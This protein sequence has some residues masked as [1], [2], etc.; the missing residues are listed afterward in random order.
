MAKRKYARKFSRCNIK[1]VDDLNG[2]KVSV[3][4]GTIAD[5]VLSEDYP[6]IELVQEKKYLI[7]AENVLQGKTDAIVMDILPAKEIVK[8]NP[9]LV[10]LDQELFTDTYG[11]AVKKGNEELLENINNILEKLMN[12]GKIEEYTLKYLGEDDV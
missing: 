4:L 6:E 8:Q 7:A 10:I 1:S 11:I 2:K 9:E 3:Q 12:E 5:I